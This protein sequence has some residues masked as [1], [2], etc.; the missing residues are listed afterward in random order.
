MTL[1][2]LSCDHRHRRQRRY[3][4]YRTSAAEVFVQ[5][6]ARE[7]DGDRGI[8]RADYY[9]IVQTPDLR[10]ADEDDCA[11][12]IENACSEGN[13]QHRRGQGAEMPSE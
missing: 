1:S 4:S 9:R 8:E 11:G 3:H 12:D 10:C 5:K 2:F 13:S 7:K 6:D